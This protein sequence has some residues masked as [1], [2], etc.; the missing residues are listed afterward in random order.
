MQKVKLKC[1]QNQ[2]WNTNHV[3]NGSYKQVNYKNIVTEKT[4]NDLFV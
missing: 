3:G 2:P 1:E 4:V